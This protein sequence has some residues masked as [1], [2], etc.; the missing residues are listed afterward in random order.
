[1]APLAKQKTTAK[2]NKTIP[3]S[4][5]LLVGIVGS[6]GWSNGFFINN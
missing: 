5:R 4:V 1:M 3:T 6:S 2:K